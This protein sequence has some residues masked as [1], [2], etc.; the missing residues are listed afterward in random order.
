MK[1]RKFI[2][3]CCHGAITIPLGISFLQSCGTIYY[4][5]FSLQSGLLTVSRSEFINTKKN[6]QVPRSFVLIK[7]DGLNFPICLS[8]ISSDSYIAS[9]L[10]CTHRNCELN[11]GGG[12]YSCPCHGSEFSITG[13]VLQGP[14][15]KNLQTF[16]TKTDNENIYI[17]LN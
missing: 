12:I 4:A 6:K 15:D 5:T 7:T 8:K 17:F 3:L 9:L 13:K 11:V 14:A 1:R 10:K 2:T 16:K